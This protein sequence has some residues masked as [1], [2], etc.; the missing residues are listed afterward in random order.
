MAKPMHL[1][2]YTVCLCILLEVCLYF[3][4]ECFHIL[5]VEIQFLQR[6]LHIALRSI[7][8]EFIYT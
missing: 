2:E 7:S 4:I 8:S 3:L 6:H 5:K 1:S